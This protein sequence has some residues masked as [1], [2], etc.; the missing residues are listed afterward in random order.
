MKYANLLED[1]IKNRVAK[2]Y[3]W[4]Y[5]WATIIG[6]IDFCVT[7]HQSDLIIEEKSHLFWAEAKK[8]SSDIYKSLIQLILTI[9]KARTFDKILPPNFIGAFDA[10]KIAFLPY[11]NIYEVFYLN[12]FNWNVTPSNHH[13]KEFKLLYEIVKNTI[14]KNALLFEFGKDDYE[15]KKFIKT[16]FQPSKFGNQK[17]K[18]DK[19]NFMIIYNKWLQTVKPTIAV[20]WNLAKKTGIID[21]DFYLADLLSSENQTLKDKLYVLLKNDHYQL[22]RKFNELGLFTTSQTGFL[23]KQKAHQQF[24]NKYERPPKEIYWDYIVERRDLLVPQDI[25]ER[26]GSFFTPQ[27]WVELSQEYFAKTFGEDWQ[28]EY[29]I[30]DCAA[31]TGNLLNGLTNKYKIYAST[32]DKQDVDIIHDRIE[33]GANLLPEHVFQFDFLNDE[34]IPK[35][36]GGKLP[37]S[38]Y[39]IITDE[40]K[41]KKLVIYMNPPYAEAT[42]AK[43]VTKTGENKA[44]VV[45]RFP[46]KDK[47]HAKIGNASNE[48]FALFFARIYEEL[49]GCIM[50][51]FSTLKFVQGTNFKKFREE[52]FLAKYLGGFVIPSYTFDNVKGKFPIGFTIWNTAIHEKITEIICDVYLKYE[53]KSDSQKVFYGNL[54]ESL[55][56]WIVE[57]Q[58]ETDN[59]IIGLLS[60]YPPDF[61]NQNK[62]FIQIKH[63]ERSGSIKICPQNLITVSIYFTVRKV[64]KATWLND[65]DQ[66]LYPNN[67]WQK[68]KIFQ[69]NCLVYT[70]FHAQNRISC[71][72]GTNHWIPFSE[73]EV[74][75]KEAFESNFMYNFI[76]G[77]IKKNNG[78]NFFGFI[79]M[80]EEASYGNK[81]LQ[82]SPQAQAVLDAGKE[83][84]K[85]YHAQH[86]IHVNASFYDIKEYFQGRNE[87]GNLNPKSTDE[88]YNELMEILKIKMEALAFEIEP[89]VYE[90]GFLML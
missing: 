15:I 40:K 90:Y 6:K 54:P 4:L 63:T 86:N 62:V 57:F 87:N 13:T 89:K 71:K 88:K 51:S 33:S 50:G 70:F 27:I 75:S 46:L 59:E 58:S 35:S 19:N 43:T 48:F 69:S 28:D 22:D 55:N 52:F 5:D 23:D 32:L 3:F 80:E 53:K 14:E 81:P 66:F 38:L 24:W 2:D 31:G 1:E 65:R 7:F 56:K 18:V 20:N 49:Q 78:F 17:I 16:N 10:E 30:W 39:K 44:G 11:E 73:I 36:Q 72:H 8:G 25:R 29:F 61:Q 79:V 12:D 85:Y 26:K 42:S 47:Y 37:D 83:L 67:K 34:F 41:R 77:K 74:L 68:D 60:N 82:F 45:K 9:G 64:I 76:H 84:W 21:G